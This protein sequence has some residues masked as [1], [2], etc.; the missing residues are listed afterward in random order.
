MRP[1]LHR[2]LLVLALALGA[3]PAAAQNAAPSAAEPAWGTKPYAEEKPLFDA[4]VDDL[5]A[6]IAAIDERIAKTAADRDAYWQDWTDDERQQARE[7]F[8]RSTHYPPAGNRLNWAKEQSSAATQRF[9]AVLESGRDVDLAADDDLAKA[10]RERVWSTQLAALRARLAERNEQA[11]YDGIELQAVKSYLGS[12]INRD[13]GISVEEFARDAVE[14]TWYVYR[15]A[16]DKFWDDLFDCAVK[17]VGRD[18]LRHYIGRK[19]PT[20]KLPPAMPGEVS[21]PGGVVVECISD[22]GRAA[23]VNAFTAALRKDF[24]DRWTAHGIY[25]EVAEYWWAHFILEGESETGPNAKRVKPVLQ[26]IGDRLLDG[27]VR[28][29]ENFDQT[30]LEQAKEVV[31]RDLEIEGRKRLI[32]AVQEEALKAARAAQ[33]EHQRLVGVALRQESVRAAAARLGPNLYAKDWKLRFADTMD[34]LEVLMRQGLVYFSVTTSEQEFDLLSKPLT[35]EYWDVVRCLGKLERGTGAHLVLQFY[36]WDQDVR[37]EFFDTCA[38][39]REEQNL[40]EAQVMVDRMAG[41]ASRASS[42]ASE[43]HQYCSSAEGQIALVTSDIA[44]I[45][46]RITE[47]ENFWQNSILASMII[48]GEIDGIDQDLAK[49][50]SLAEEAERAK[51]QVDAAAEQACD[52]SEQFRADTTDQG[53]LD[54]IQAAVATARERATASD[55]A[56]QGAGEAARRAYTSA[57]GV[58]QA[59]ADVQKFRDAGGDLARV[60]DEADATLSLVERDADAARAAGEKLAAVGREGSILIARAR[61]LLGTGK[62]T[63]AVKRQLDTVET[64]YASVQAA[65]GSDNGCAKKVA[66]AAATLRQ[67]LAAARTRFESVKAQI[68]KDFAGSDVEGLANDVASAG[69][70]ARA[71]ADVAE[72]IAGAALE[73]AADAETCLKLAQAARQ[74]QDTET[75]AA[76]RAAIAQCDFPTAKTLITRLPTGPERKDLVDVYRAAYDRERVTLDLWK[77]ADAAYR[78][79]QFDDAYEDLAEAEANTQCD[80]YRARLAEAMS[81]VTKAQ[82]DAYAAQA[83]AALA[84]CD[85]DRAETLVRALE[86]GGWPV[87]AEL[88][89]A[90]EAAAAREEQALALYD[91][92]EGQAD[93]GNT[94]PALAALRQA[95]GVTQCADLRNEI[96]ALIASLQ[97]TQTQDQ[98]EVTPAPTPDTPIAPTGAWTG[99]WQGTMQLRDLVVDGQ[100]MSPRDLVARIDR[101]WEA[102]V[103]RRNAENNPLTPM[104]LDIAGNMKEMVKSGLLLLGGPLPI[105]FALQPEGGGYRLALPGAPP[106]SKDNPALVQFVQALPVLVADGQGGWHADL[107]D[108]GSTVN[109]TIG[110]AD[111]LLSKVNFSLSLHFQVPGDVQDAGSSFNIRSLTLAIAGSADAGETGYADLVAEYQRLLRERAGR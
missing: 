36:G 58:V 93:L 80:A 103:G 64:L 19:D 1:T 106:P 53:K 6:K 8:Q 54:Q 55:K 87:A 24:V 38:K 90:L 27:V 60:L 12:L 104:E 10:R 41:I 110:A 81:R 40:P 71:T 109:L 11:I 33:T 16:A 23:L 99:P 15:A 59:L 73:T 3:V 20:F 86:E 44:T 83:S 96:A 79:G 105:S 68:E 89:A 22:L 107:S 56:A 50:T 95:Q 5:Q 111:T 28:T 101:E 31:K 82:V 32:K 37:R 91:Q 94:A 98:G 78:A 67:R 77:S 52:M 45:E 30:T 7:W 4:A 65:A 21:A 42:L 84:N 46:A 74:G 85:F 97:G 43:L 70:Q 18:V 48:E 62:Q 49:A 61:Q 63:D 76:A 47:M 51:K 108:K 14:D 2:L 100:R 69:E 25:P 66:A 88:R 102:Y 9:Q 35:D 39:A 75:A 26:A 17:M 92:G 29:F 13:L 72:A 57:E 34:G